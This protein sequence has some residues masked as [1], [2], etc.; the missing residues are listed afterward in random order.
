MKAI[1]RLPVLVL[2]ILVVL[3]CAGGAAKKAAGSET[4]IPENQGSNYF[5]DNFIDE[6]EF[7]FDEVE[8][9][10]SGMAESLEGK[11][12]I[13]VGRIS[14]ADTQTVTML[15][16]WLKNCIIFSARKYSDKIRIASVLESS[17]FAMESRGFT[18]DVPPKT[19]SIQ[20][21]ITGNYLPCE[22]GAE[23]FLNLVSAGFNRPV[24]GSAYFIIPRQELDD[25]R[26]SLLPDKDNDTIGP[27]EYKAKQEALAP[28]DGKDNK[29][30]FTVTPDVLDG[31]YYDGD[32]M[33]MSI[34]SERSCYFR[35]VHVDVYGNT[36]VIY[37]A[38]YVDD[39]FIRAGETRVIP[40]N[41][42]YR[43]GPPFGE[44]FILAAGYE[45]PYMIHSPPAAAPL[46][47]D[48]ILRNFSVETD[49]NTDMK[50]SV[51]AKFPYSILPR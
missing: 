48:T 3:S 7:F 14:Y 39:N 11:T 2:L 50:P 35:V 22:E 13:A 21:V 46:S 31:I 1:I 44:E 30:T 33:Y 23:I 51:T 26:L 43:M 40:D 41:T 25:K 27:E 17:A 37:P 28:Y 8:A 4:V 12:T 20:A 38:A 24:L 42:L 16:A 18:T 15:S 47:E 10:V 34:Y 9:A 29:W 19:D 5:P 36:Q 6:K 49:S 32:H 45:E